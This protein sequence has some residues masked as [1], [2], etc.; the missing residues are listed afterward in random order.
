MIDALDEMLRQ[1]GIPRFDESGIMQSGMIIRHLMLPG[2]LG[3]TRQ[4]LSK[5]AE[6]YGDRVLVSLMRQY[7]PFDMQAYP[8]LDRKIT[9]EEY[10]EAV[11]WFELVGLNGFLQDEESMSESFIPSFQGEGF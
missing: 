10:A 6:R 4:V 2:L 1:V 5:I 11:E 8:E 9:D 7:T 3:D